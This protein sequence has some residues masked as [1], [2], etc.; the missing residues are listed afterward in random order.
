[1]Q[2]EYFTLYKEFLSSKSKGPGEFSIN[3]DK[4]Q[5]SC[6]HHI[7]PNIMADADLEDHEGRS[8]HDN[9]SAITQAIVDVE[10]CMM[11]SKIAHLLK[12]LLKK[13]RSKCGPAK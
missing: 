6:K 4:L 3:S 7:M 8:T 12:L 13:K 9:S 1:M 2:K 10:T 11:S 5:I